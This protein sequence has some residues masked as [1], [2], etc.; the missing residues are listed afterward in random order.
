MGKRSSLENEG[1]NAPSP[2][3][4]AVLW[5]AMLVYGGWMATASTTTCGSRGCRNC[6]TVSLEAFV[7]SGT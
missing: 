3:W 1:G 4:V 2:A 7:P 5:E 6:S